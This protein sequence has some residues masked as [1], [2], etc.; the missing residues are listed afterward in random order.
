MVMITGS[1]PGAAKFMRSRTPLKGKSIKPREKLG[2][3]LGS[4]GKAWGG[5]FSYP[6]ARAENRNTSVRRDK[7]IHFFT[8]LA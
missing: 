4:P 5:W 3:G 8:A 1:R 7:D 2:K 6:C